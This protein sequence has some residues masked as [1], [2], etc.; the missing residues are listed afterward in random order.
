MILNHDFDMTWQLS[1]F[2]KFWFSKSIS[3]QI[4]RLDDAS[5]CYIRRNSCFFFF[6]LSHRESMI[7]REIDS[8]RDLCECVRV[9]AVDVFTVMMF[10]FDE[11]TNYHWQWCVATTQRSCRDLIA[12]TKILLCWYFAYISSRL[13]RISIVLRSWNYVINALSMF[14]R[15]FARII[16]FFSCN[17]CLQ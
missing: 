3:S 4:F 11:M 9:R 12:L 5:L 13:M 7:W 16:I 10:C 17:N 15:L 6:F 14:C 2:L 8:S 1:S